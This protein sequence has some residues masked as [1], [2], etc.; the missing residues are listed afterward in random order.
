MTDI[1]LKVGDL[2]YNSDTCNSNKQ[3]GIIYDFDNIGEWPG[4]EP[5]VK[6]YWQVTQATFAYYLSA[7]IYRVRINQRWIHYPTGKQ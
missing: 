2:V 7:V 6:I 1:E 4:D 5:M 3:F